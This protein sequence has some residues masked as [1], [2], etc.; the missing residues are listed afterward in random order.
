MNCFKS[1]FNNKMYQL[2][3]F[4]FFFLDIIFWRQRFDIYAARKCVVGRLL[5]AGTMVNTRNLKDGGDDDDNDDGDDIGH[6]HL[7]LFCIE[8]LNLR[9]HALYIA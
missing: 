9:L 4:Q 1:S 2:L 8:C 7:I 5:L 3:S 6:L